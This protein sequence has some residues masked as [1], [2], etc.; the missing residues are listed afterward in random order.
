MDT[1]SRTEDVISQLHQT[2]HVKIIITNETELSKGMREELEENFTNLYSFEEVLSEGKNSLS[3]NSNFLKPSP[4]DFAQICFTS[5][6]TGP[7]KGVL[8]THNNLVSA[9]KSVL[10]TMTPFID[11]SQETL[12]SFI[13]LSQSMSLVVEMMMYSMG[14]KVAIYSGEI[15]HLIEDF[16]VSKPTILVTIPR[17][18]DNIYNRIIYSAKG[19]QL[20]TKL[21]AKALKNQEKEIS[22]GRGG[23]GILQHL[24][25]RG[26]RTKILGGQ[27]K[28][29][30][31][32]AG[33][34]SPNVLHFLRVALGCTILDSYGLIECSGFATIT[35][36]KNYHSYHS[37]GPL[38]CNEIK[39]IDL[40]EFRYVV[41]ETGIGEICIKGENVSP[42]YFD[43]SIPAGRGNFLDG[44]LRTG[45][46]GSWT[47]DHKLKVIERKENIIRLKSGSFV[48][49]ERIQSVYNQSAYV[50][51]CF[52]DADDGQNFLIAI[53]VPEIDYLNRWCVQNRLILNTEQACKDI[54][55]KQYVMRDMLSTGEREGL[56][57]HEQVRNIYLHPKAFSVENNLLTPIFETRRTYCKQFFRSILQDLSKF[58]VDTSGGNSRR[59][60]LCIS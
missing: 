23:K 51:E 31:N 36:F 25:F 33:P 3:V 39:L 29:I 50:S 15:R 58:V 2:P 1:L 10:E 38:S 46:I 42:G 37:G 40:P 35:A 24:A 32:G 13:P 22:Q 19:S 20:Q 30:I 60:S 27:V 41:S 34:L 7:P 17:F 21:M 44:W 48:A 45:D 59:E 11:L 18:L 57:P 56:R 55:F 28:L 4:N 47:E 53:V 6:T 43:C 54:Q 8:Q 26:Q 14:G 5:G 12:L 16:Q 49:P 9:M 52:V